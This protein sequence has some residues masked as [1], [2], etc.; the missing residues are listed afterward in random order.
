MKVRFSRDALADLSEILDYVAARNPAAAARLADEFERTA[1]L[2]GFMPG[3]GAP[4]S[5]PNFRRA[6]CGNYLVVYE[7]KQE[8]AIIQYVRHGARLRPWEN[9]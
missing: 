5:R 9:E 7:L 2:I 3:V 8:E 4:A 6:V 1:R